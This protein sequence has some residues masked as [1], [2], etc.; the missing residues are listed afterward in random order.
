MQQPEETTALLRRW[1]GGQEDALHELMPRVYQE[2]HILARRYM[3]GE[4]AG[5]TLQATALVNEAFVKMLGADVEWSERAHFIAVAARQMRRIL[6]DHAKARR[7]HKRGGDAIRVTLDDGA[8]GQS[9]RPAD[10][11]SLDRALER[12]SETDDRKG[13]IVELSYFGGLTTAEIAEALALSS[14]T[15]ERELR[16]GKAWLNRALRESPSAD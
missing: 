1:R 13:T 10:L 3:G 5:H 16:F 6:V 4:R 9:D 7:A 11:L 15:V 8:I 14:A 12:L 2:L